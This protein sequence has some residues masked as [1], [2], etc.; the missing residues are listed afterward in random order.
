M[1][2]CMQVCDVR[3]VILTKRTIYSELQFCTVQL[4][5]CSTLTKQR[6]VKFH[7]SEVRRLVCLSEAAFL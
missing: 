1:T 3:S 6:V 5:T 4:T 2:R 7:G